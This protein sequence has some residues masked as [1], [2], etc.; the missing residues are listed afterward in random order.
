M[1]RVSLIVLLVL[2]GLSHEV[3]SEN[4]SPATLLNGIVKIQAQNYL[5][6]SSKQGS[7]II[8]QVDQD[9]VVILTASHVVTGDPH[10][11]IEFYQHAGR[12]HES[13]VVPGSELDNEQDGLALLRVSPSD[14]VPFDIQVLPLSPSSGDLVTG[15]AVSVLSLPRGVN[16]WTVLHGSL[17][18][19]RGREIIVD[20]RGS[21][22]SSGGAIVRGGKMI[23]VVQRLDEFLRGNSAQ[24]VQDFLVGLGIRVVIQMLPPTMTGADGAPMI[25]VPG[26][27]FVMGSDDRSFSGVSPAHRVYL[28]AFYM[29]QFEVTTARYH[30][31]MEKTGHAPPHD[32]YWKV[33]GI[34]GVGKV[35]ASE[36]YPQLPVVN[37]TWE[38]ADQYCRWA[39]KRLPT[40]AEWEKAA[41]GNDGRAY[42]WGNE[43]LSAER[44][45][46]FL[47]YGD[48]PNHYEWMKPIGSY[49]GGKSPYGIDDLAG[50]VRE[51]VADWFDELYYAESPRS[52]PQGPLVGR[53]G[54]FSSGHDKVVRGG[55][56]A[57]DFTFLSVYRQ[58]AHVSHGFRWDIGFRC[59]QNP[60]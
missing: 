60:S 43:P 14:R 38:E 58:Y 18:A 28:D 26:G 46:K 4:P 7:G 57:Y 21:E 51:W 3:R 52:N 47:S 53:A 9:G 10:P 48:S 8:V 44:T 36:K 2:A 25:L 11:R 32:R 22:G 45:S 37:V 35:A 17:V 16:D 5:T 41:R 15:E 34:L 40:E 1:I 56:R 31:F 42:P 59:A 49:P 33:G 50:S 13:T 30:Q 6:G 55:D 29:D 23:G 20:V 39:G 27:E 12:I 19:R 24:S 54:T